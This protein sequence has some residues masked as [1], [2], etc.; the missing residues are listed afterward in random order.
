MPARSAVEQLTGK[1]RAD[2]KMT[3]HNLRINVSVLAGELAG[4]RKPKALG[5]PVQGGVMPESLCAPFFA[6]KR[7]HYA[8]PSQSIADPANM[9]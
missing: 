3:P 9:P 7:N 2:P 5:D 6:F 8:P 4:R 1:N